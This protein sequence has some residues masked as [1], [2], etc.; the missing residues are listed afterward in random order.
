MVGVPD[1][2]GRREI[3]GIHTRGMPLAEDVDLQHLARQTYGFVGADIAA[4]A[5]EAAIEAVRRIMP[6]INLEEGTIPPEV[7]DTLSV[8]R[9]DFEQAIKRVQ[10]SAKREAWAGAQCPRGGLGGLDEV[11]K[12]CARASS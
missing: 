1:E 10:P 3:L 2:T 11:E 8:T 12:G 7:L 4:L 6:K 5:R 9:S